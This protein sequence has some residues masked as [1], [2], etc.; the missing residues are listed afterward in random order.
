MDVPYTMLETK[1][2][3]TLQDLGMPLGERITAE[4][5][6]RDAEFQDL[7]SKITSDDYR[8]LS[9]NKEVFSSLIFDD[10][11]DEQIHKGTEDQPLLVRHAQPYTGLGIE[12]EKYGTNEETIRIFYS[13]DLD[14]Q[15]GIQQKRHQQSVI[16]AFYKNISHMATS[17]SVRLNSDIEID[18]DAREKA[19]KDCMSLKPHLENIE[20]LNGKQFN[21]A[22]V[23]EFM[24][25]I[26][27]LKESL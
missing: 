19:Y 15:V 2:E 4:D 6:N 3:Q 16:H 23:D 17:Y 9:D 24:T 13:K 5:L 1:L 25:Y 27:E 8:K 20:S 7:T 11:S 14:W 12:Y 10:L 18:N 22:T 21:E 26:R